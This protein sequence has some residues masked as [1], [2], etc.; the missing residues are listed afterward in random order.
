[1]A[2]AGSAALTPWGHSP[3]GKKNLIQIRHAQL[4]Y[5]SVGLKLKMNG[6]SCGELSTGEYQ[7]QYERS[8]ES[9]WVWTGGLEARQGVGTQDWGSPLYYLDTKQ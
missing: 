5:L 4:N 8:S 7:A 6:P 2:T 3:M 1:M 9:G